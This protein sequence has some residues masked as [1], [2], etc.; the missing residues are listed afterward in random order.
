MRRALVLLTSVLLVAA[1]AAP[2][3]TTATLVWRH[4]AHVYGIFDVVGPR[5]DGR[6][7]V[8]G[9]NGLYLLDAAQRL[10]RFAPSYGPTGDGAESYIALSPGL[11]EPGPNCLFRQDAVAA[12][13]VAPATPGVTLISPSGT[14]THLAHI[15]GVGSLYGITF[16]TTGRFGNRLLVIGKRADGRTQVSAVDCRG[17]VATIGVFTVPLE[18]GVAVAPPS[19]GAFGGDLIAPNELDGSIYAVSPS[20]QLALVAKSGQPSGGD[21]GVES[22]GFVPPSGA[23]AAVM[24]D[25]ATAGNPHP[26]TDHVLVLP[27]A[28]LRAEGIKP[29]DLLAGTEGGATMVQVRCVGARCTVQTIVALPTTAHGEG[30]LTVL[31]KAGPVGSH[32]SRPSHEARPTARRTIAP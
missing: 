2:R 1:P 8:A 9:A 21:I 20:G 23:G 32:R 6:L 16:D 7:V 15:T 29:G 30:S 5:S 28:A 12:L 19:F 31:P 4:G 18:G 14:P 26:G 17:R 22:L 11:R 27:G 25:R 3:P 10:S 13:V 24:A